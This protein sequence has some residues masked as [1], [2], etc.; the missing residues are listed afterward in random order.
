MFAKLPSIQYYLHTYKDPANF[1]KFVC[2]TLLFTSGTQGAQTLLRTPNC[3][4]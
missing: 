2:Q 1:L 4:V 3:K